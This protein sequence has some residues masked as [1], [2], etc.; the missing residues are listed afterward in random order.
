[1]H[2]VKNLI[3]IE[4]NIKLHL[5]KSMK[6]NSKVIAVS[7]TFKSKF[8]LLLNTVIFTMEKIKFRK[9]LKNGQKLN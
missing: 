7:K 4:N 8:Y 9:Q 5:N 6:C 3:D 1:M 2:D